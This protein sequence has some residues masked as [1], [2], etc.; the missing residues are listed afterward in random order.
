[1]FSFQPLSRVY[2]HEVYSII[3]EVFLEVPMQI[4]SSIVFWNFW[5][6][7]SQINY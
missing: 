2:E 5:T 6:L 3:D 7:K 1:M 4:I